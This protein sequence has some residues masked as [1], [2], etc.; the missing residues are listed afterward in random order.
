MTDSAFQKVIRSV[1]IFAGI[2]VSA[3][4]LFH[5]AGLSAQEKSIPDHSGFKD[6]QPCHAEKYKAWEST[7]H[8]KAIDRLT[9]LPKAG[10]DCYVCH[11][12]EGFAAKLQE[13][14]VDPAN[15]GSFHSVSCTACHKPGSKTNPKQLAMNSEKLCVDCHS[16]QQGTVVT[17]KGAKGIEDTRS[18][19]SAV[20]CVS[21]HMSEANHDL[22]VI[23]PDDPKL[24]E[25]KLD[26]CTRCHKD[27]NRKARA[28]QLTDW[29]TFYKKAM[30]PVEADITAINAR[31]KEKPD[32]LNAD[33]KAKLSD[34]NANLS[35]IRRDRSR[36]AHNLDFALEILEKASKD[37]KEIKAAIK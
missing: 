15:A 22:K 16:Q 29:Q 28:K 8:S 25:G 27:N 13:N 10:A 7:G 32:M 6:C 21:C 37:I 2:M 33:L 14:K 23:R 11:T 3:M 18:F 30:D 12:A 35:L 4:I 36:G 34:I 19:H 1:L 17:G 26:T 9:S 5:V 20:P 24:P 31:L